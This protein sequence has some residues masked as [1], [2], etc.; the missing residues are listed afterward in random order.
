MKKRT[1]GGARKGAGRPHHSGE[2]NVSVTIRISHS[3]HERAKVYAGERGFSEW[4]R[5]LIEEEMKRHD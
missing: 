1:W 2:H 5:R 3:L 4:L